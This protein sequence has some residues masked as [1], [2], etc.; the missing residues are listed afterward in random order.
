[1]T[2][3]SWIDDYRDEHGTFDPTLVKDNTLGSLIAKHDEFAFSL[4]MKRH[5]SRINAKIRQSLNNEVECDTISKTYERIWNAAPNW[6]PNRASFKTFTN[7]ILRNT[8]NEFYRTNLR[9][10]RTR[11]WSFTEN[12]P[13]DAA[14]HLY[15]E[16]IE[17]LKQMIQ[18]ETTNEINQR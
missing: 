16:P 1:M 17:P 2:T 15:N 8:I 9:N 18:D 6:N 10:Q 3:S 14:I 13:E 5:K 12:P 4:F 7:A 11:P